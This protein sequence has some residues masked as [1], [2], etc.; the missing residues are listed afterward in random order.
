MFVVSV[1]TVCVIFIS[2]ESNTNQNQEGAY[3][4]V[5]KYLWAYI[6]F[7]AANGHRGYVVRMDAEY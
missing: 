3:R 6:T 7:P 5:D 4:S 1:L 2:P